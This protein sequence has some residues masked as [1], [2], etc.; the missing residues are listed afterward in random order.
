M[1]DD[2]IR[3]IVEYA[4]VQ[5]KDILSQRGDCPREEALRVLVSARRIEQRRSSRRC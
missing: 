4:H 5:A 1:I 3:R 2:E